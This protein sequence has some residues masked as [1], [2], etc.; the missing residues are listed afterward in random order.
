MVVEHNLHIELISVTHVLR[1]CTRGPVSD[2]TIANALV[3]FL[4]PEYLL[5]PIQHTESLSFY[6]EV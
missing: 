5:T 3:M 1:M 4:Q 2:D 6:L